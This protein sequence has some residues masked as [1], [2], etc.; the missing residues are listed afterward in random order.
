M[1]LL[2]GIQETRACER[3]LDAIREVVHGVAALFQG[4]LGL[5]A[6]G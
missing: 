4:L 1:L 2:L 3:G 6:P 5:S